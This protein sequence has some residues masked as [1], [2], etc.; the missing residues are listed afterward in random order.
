MMRVDWANSDWAYLLGVVHGDGHV[1]R[2][3]I[4]ISVG[5]SDI[6]YADALVGVCKRLG[7][8]AKVYYLRSALRV[9]VHS[10]ELATLFRSFKSHGKW[11]LPDGLNLNEWIAGVYDTDGSISVTDKKCAILL[12]LKRNGNVDL[13]AQSFED[14]G[15]KKPKVRH[16]VGKYLGEDYQVESIGIANFEGMLEFANNIKLRHYRK[17]PLLNKITKYIDQSKSKIPKWKMVAAYCAEPRTLKE[18]AEHFSMTN[19]QVESAL[20]NVRKK[21]DLL[22]IPPQTTLTRYQVKSTALSPI[23]E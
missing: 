7:Y 18:I 5:Y 9:D 1:S 16:Y 10:S 15:M 20:Q 6:E 23:A 8:E 17:A 4:E 14:I 19:H 22:T 2:R 21:M 13:V 12:R 3:S 11:H